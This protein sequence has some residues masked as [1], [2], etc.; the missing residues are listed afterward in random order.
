MTS[1]VATTA[2]PDPTAPPTT[3]TDEAKPHQHRMAQQ[4]GDT[5]VTALHHMANTVADTGAEAHAGDVIVA[6]AIEKAEGMY[7]MEDGELTWRE[8][9]TENTHVEISVRDAS[10]NR[11]VPGLSVHVTIHDA[12]GSEVAA[13]EVSYLWHPW[14]YHYGKNFT[15]PGDGRYN[16]DVKVKA[17]TYHRHDK[18]NGRRYAEEVTVTFR[19]VP[20]EVGKA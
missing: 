15:L 19:D 13:D 12:D 18:E 7:V 8:P 3:A 5:Y 9:G 16:L 6:L 4:Q 10:D 1:D 17:P 2:R 20:I 14:L 11:F